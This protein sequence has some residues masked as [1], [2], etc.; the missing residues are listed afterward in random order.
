MN[1]KDDIRFV[2][3]LPG[4]VYRKRERILPALYKHWSYP[5][6]LLQRPFAARNIPIN[7]DVRKFL[8]LKGEHRNKRCFIIGNGPS[9]KVRDLTRLHAKGEISFAFN[10]IYLAF[11]ESP[12]RPTYYIVEDPLVAEN[13]R[14]EILKLEPFVKFFPYNFRY[15]FKKA[16]NAFFYTLDWS[17]FFPGFP[18]IT[19]DPFNLFWGATVTSTAIQLAVY[20]GCNPIYL[21]GMD[22]SFTEPSKKD[23]SRKNVLVSQGER[24]HFHPLYR[25]EGEKWFAP[26]L[27][28]QRKTFEA[29]QK[30]CLA[31]GIKIVNASRKTRLDV[32]ET[33]DLDGILRVAD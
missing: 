2:L 10:K 6:Q 13:A 8:N 12:F 1:I 5:F 9:L 3:S 11:D 19:C 30:Y 33:E 32:F 18:R 22:F 14:S 25:A 15:L 4:I 24:N 29:I 17:D 31:H 7:R 21:I 28:H 23:E 26:R 20:F 27:E 16:S